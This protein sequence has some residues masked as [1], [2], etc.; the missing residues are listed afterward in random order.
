MFLMDAAIFGTIS[1]PGPQLDGYMAYK[2]G[3]SFLYFTASSV[4]DTLF[5]K[6]LTVRRIKKRRTG[7]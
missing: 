6:C 2:G 3:Q 7:F 1:Q 5:P 4:G